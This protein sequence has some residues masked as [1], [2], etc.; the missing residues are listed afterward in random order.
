MSPVNDEL[1]RI[2]KEKTQKK[3]PTVDLLMQILPIGKEAAYRRLRGEI[4]F[5]LNEAVSICKAL[6]ISLDMMIGHTRKK[7][8]T[9]HLNAFFLNEPMEEYYKMLNNITI[10]VNYLADKHPAIYSYR[11]YRTIPSEFLYNYRS[12][13]K[14]YIHVIFYQLYTSTKINGFPNMYIPEKIFTKQA[15]VASIS[16][17]MDS[18]LIFDKRIFID[19]IDI[20]L[21][22]RDM[23][24]I[25]EESMKKVKTELH[26]LLNDIEKCAVS[27]MTLHKSK[28]DIYISNVS[29]DCTYTYM[30]A[31]EH[32]YCSIG[33]F[34]LN[35]LSCDEPE[36]VESHKLWI[37][38]LIR[39]STLV[40]ASGEIYRN[41]YFSEQRRFIDTML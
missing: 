8:H 21:Y 29:F 14:I 6:S 10:A 40:S 22:F 38:S 35:H 33:L 4:P 13:S 26:S 24:M 32:K 20:I 11:A 5:T 34:S 19:Y 12:L 3:E 2:L 28:L 27:G 41:K 36:I 7:T 23:G 15:E 18:I 9:F 25:N 1:I 31:G 30:E 37:K 39:F 17:D 16:Q